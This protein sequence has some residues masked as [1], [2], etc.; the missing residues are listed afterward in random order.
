MSWPIHPPYNK[1]VTVLLLTSIP[2]SSRG[3]FC[4]QNTLLI[5][6]KPCNL[7]YNCSNKTLNFNC[8]RRGI[9]QKHR[10]KEIIHILAHSTGF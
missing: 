8:V 6:A 4:L 1:L 9:E 5:L 7:N 10:H 3:I 2:L